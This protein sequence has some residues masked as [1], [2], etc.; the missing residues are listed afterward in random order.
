MIFLPFWW[1]KCPFSYER[2]GMVDYSFLKGPQPSSLPSGYQLP[3]ALRTA[4]WHLAGES[5][6]G[7]RVRAVH[8]RGL[9]GTGDS[10]QAPRKNH[11]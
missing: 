11:L 3:A 4:G 8:S 10:R 9:G 6:A 1:Q 2:M 7:L 5:R